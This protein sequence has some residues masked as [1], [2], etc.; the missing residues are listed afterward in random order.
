[1]L[2]ETHA[3]TVLAEYS[4]RLHLPAADPLRGGPELD[5]LVEACL[6]GSVP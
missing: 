6:A 5:R 1:M 4:E 2:D 3:R